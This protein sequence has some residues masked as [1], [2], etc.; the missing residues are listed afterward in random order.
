M[1]EHALIP[2]ETFLSTGDKE[3]VFTKKKYM[4]IYSKVYE[5]CI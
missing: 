2:L 5:L 4:Q 1:R 3:V